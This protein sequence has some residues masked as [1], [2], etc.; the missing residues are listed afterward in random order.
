VIN[1]ADVTATTAPSTGNPIRKKTP[2]RHTESRTRENFGRGRLTTTALSATSSSSFTQRRTRAQHMRGSRRQA[3][4]SC[5]PVLHAP[6]LLCAV[7][8]TYSSRRRQCAADLE[9]ESPAVAG[10]SEVGGTGLEPVTP[11]LSTRG[12]RSR[13]FG[14]VRSTRT[15]AR[16]QPCER[17]PHRTAAAVE[18]PS[19]ANPVY[20]WAVTLALA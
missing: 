4:N 11:S 12:D 18:R 7:G 17:T 6:A 20:T 14:Q 16:F 3:S 10:L 15:A 19:S 2:S 13:R 1:Q 9:R 8:L 5:P